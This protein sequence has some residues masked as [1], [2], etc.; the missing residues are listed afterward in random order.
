L[1]REGNFPL[2]RTRGGEERGEW[3]RRKARRSSGA[4]RNVRE[5]KR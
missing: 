2:E 3:Y 1:K 4:K 5:I